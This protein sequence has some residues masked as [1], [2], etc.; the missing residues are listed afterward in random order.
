MWVIIKTV[1]IEKIISREYRVRRRQPRM[2][3]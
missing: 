2:E 3:P 1:G